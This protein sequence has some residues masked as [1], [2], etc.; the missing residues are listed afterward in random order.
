MTIENLVF[1]DRHDPEFDESLTDAGGKRFLRFAVDVTAGRSKRANWRNE[2]VLGCVYLATQ[3]VF[4]Q[5]DD[6]YFP[7]SSALGADDEAVPGV[8]RA[9][10]PEAE[11]A[12]V[13]R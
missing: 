7:A 11:V 3:Q 6:E 12:T 10:E 5:R 8:C 2:A 4:I 13:A 1:F 9:A